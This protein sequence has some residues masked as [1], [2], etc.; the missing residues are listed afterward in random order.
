MTPRRCTSDGSDETAFCRLAEA[1][2]VETRPLSF[3]GSAPGMRPGLLL[4][5][6]AFTPAE[7][8]AGAATLAQVFDGWRENR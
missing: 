1:A 8:D 4:G 6:A 3:Y 7:I 5:F 2:G